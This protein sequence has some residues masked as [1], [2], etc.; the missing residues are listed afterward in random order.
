VFLTNNAAA[1][2]LLGP[3]KLLLSSSFNCRSANIKGLMLQ[4]RCRG[5]ESQDYRMLWG[6]M[7]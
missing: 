2:Q 4:L 5:I 6:V 7:S 1:T 3:E